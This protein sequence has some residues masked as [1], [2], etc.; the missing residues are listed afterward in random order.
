MSQPSRIMDSRLRIIT[1][2]GRHRPGQLPIPHQIIR[3][4]SHRLLS[5]HRIIIIVCRNG[6]RTYSLSPGPRQFYLLVY[7]KWSYLTF[8]RYPKHRS[9]PKHPAMRGFPPA[10]SSES[11]PELSKVNVQVGNGESKESHEPAQDHPRDQWLPE[12]LK[13]STAPPEVAKHNAKATTS[14]N[15]WLSKI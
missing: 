7:V 2:P 14:K 11:P 9:M 8:Q 15:K 13:S 4:I 5:P 12:Q 10:K 3:L 6:L 1:T